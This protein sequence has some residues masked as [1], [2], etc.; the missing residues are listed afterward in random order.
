MADV[1]SPEIRRKNMR[2]IRG[3]D[4]KPEIKIRKLLHKHGFRYCISPKELPSKP[5]IYFPKYKACILVNGCFWHGHY[6]HM[7]KW[8]GTNKEFWGEKIS[9]TI[10]RDLKNI[11][12]LHALGIKTLVVWECAQRGKRRLP[13]SVLYQLIERWLL[14]LD[15]N[16]V[17]DA[18]GLKR[19]P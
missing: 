18:D 4:T 15:D 13:D 2:A 12:K 17:L 14:E 5:D 1:H 10:Q 19:A 16:C 9:A 11:T 7:F 3:V 6:C 8:P